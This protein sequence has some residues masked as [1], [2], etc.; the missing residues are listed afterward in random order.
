MNKISVLNKFMLVILIFCAVMT[1][2]I[3]VGDLILRSFIAD[4]GT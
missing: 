4:F 3:H 2:G 1:T